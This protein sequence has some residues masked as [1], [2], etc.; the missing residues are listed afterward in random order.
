MP[1]LYAALMHPK[2]DNSSVTHHINIV[3]FIQVNVMCVSGCMTKACK[4]CREHFV[5]N[6]CEH[7]F[8]TKWMRTVRE[9]R[10]QDSE[11]VEVVCMY[12]W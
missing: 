8:S 7:M 4:L 3:L 11:Q 10:Y 12:L 2:M 9:Q 6:M 5:N 1:D